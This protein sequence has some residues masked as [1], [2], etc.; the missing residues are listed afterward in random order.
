MY[1]FMISPFLSQLPHCIAFRWI[2]YHGGKMIEIMWI[3]IGKWGIEKIM[4]NIY[5]NYKEVLEEKIE[6]M[7]G[8]EKL[9]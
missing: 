3:L 6:K 1:G 9:E 8:E 4:K 5:I 2:I 7:E